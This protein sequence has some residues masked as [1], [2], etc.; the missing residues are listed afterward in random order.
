MEKQLSTYSMWKLFRNCRKA[1][2]WRYVQCLVRRERDAHRWLGQTIHQ[3]L[4]S[5]YEG[6]HSSIQQLIDRAYPLRAGNDDERGQWH[7]ATAMMKAYAARWAELESF[8]VINTELEFSGDIINPES[9]VQSRS[10][11]LAG[12]VDM[13]VRSGGGLWLVEHKTASIIDGNYLENLWTDFQIALYAHYI[14]MSIQEPVVGVIYNIL[15]KPMLNQRKG[16][17]EQEFEQRRAELIA[18]SKSGKSTAKQHTAES[19]DEFQARLAEK[20]SET[21]IFHREAI[22][23]S[24][25]RTRV[26]QAELWELTQALLHARR[27]DIWYQNEDH[28]FWYRR[29]CDYWPLC[30]AQDPEGVIE[31][32]YEHRDA[33]EELKNI[34]KGAL[35]GTAR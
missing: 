27:R 17:T 35:D 10:F 13:L 9:G 26:L 3:A 11:S 25:D 6:E 34:G 23:V 24:V 32:L 20:Y 15:G 30:R 29:P 5:Y 18:K 4:Q 12:K 16:E 1:Y 33:H 8:D 31:N 14:G 7:L 21:G 19:D 2:W 22:Y 28:C